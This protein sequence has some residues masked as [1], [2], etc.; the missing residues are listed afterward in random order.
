MPA[1]QGFIHDSFLLSIY[2]YEPLTNLPVCSDCLPSSPNRA[3]QSF[4][5]D[6]PYPHYTVAIIRWSLS[7]SRLRSS[8]I[9]LAGHLWAATAIGGLCKSIQNGFLPNCWLF[10]GPKYKI[11]HENSSFSFCPLSWSYPPII[12]C[13]VVRDR[14]YAS[15][16]WSY[17]QITQP[18]NSSFLLPSFP[19]PKCH[20][21]D[22]SGKQ[23][24]RGFLI[25]PFSK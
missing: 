1:L 8:H 23:I 14:Y 18:H 7:L 2:H 24:P 16:Q 15:L 20:W 21:V 4:L 9:L 6:S 25:D 22:Q 11:L 19:L 13:T 5:R 10:L 12:Q 17:L 3:S